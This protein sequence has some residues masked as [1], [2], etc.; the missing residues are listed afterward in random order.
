MCKLSLEAVIY[1]MTSY[2]YVNVDFHDDANYF[3][4]YGNIIYITYIC[5]A[6]IEMGAMGLECFE[7]VKWNNKQNLCISWQLDIAG[8]LL[9]AWL[10]T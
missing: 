7:R 3:D 8:W 2:D 10:P 5:C 1:A 9:V 6:V 4:D